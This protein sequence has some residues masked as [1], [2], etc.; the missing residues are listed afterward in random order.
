MGLI[1]LMASSMWADSAEVVHRVVD[2]ASF[3]S[4]KLLK[5]QDNGM[6]QTCFHAS[7]SDSVVGT[8]YEI[9]AGRFLFCIG[10]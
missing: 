6:R 4:D 3:P 2:L 7:L 1:Q 10:P 8:A 9:A 5:F